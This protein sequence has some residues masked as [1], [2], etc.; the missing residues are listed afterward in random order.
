MLLINRLFIMVLFIFIVLIGFM[1]KDLN[2]LLVSIVI[3]FIHNIL[4]TFEKFYNRIVFFCFNVSIFIFLVARMI[5]SKLFEYGNQSIG[6]YGT[7]FQSEDVIFKILILLNLTLFFIFLGFRIQEKNVDNIFENKSQKTSDVMIN[8]LRKVSSVI[9]LISFALRI[10]YLME[11][12]KV[13]QTNG[14]FSYFSNFQS[15]LPTPIVII[16]EMMPVAFFC[17]L[18]TFPNKKRAFSIIALYLFE[19]V[20]SMFTGSRADFMLNILIVFIYFAFR[21]VRAKNSDEV[22]WLGK[23]EWLIA[24]INLPIL[25]VI[26]NTIETIRN[27]F[28]STTSSVSGAILSFFYAQGV[29]V[30]VIGYT[31]TLK[32]SIPDKLYTFGPIIEFFKFNIFGKLSGKYTEL[33]GQTIER[34][35]EGYQ[36]SHTISYLAM[37]Q[38]YLK[39]VG[40]GSSYVAELFHDYSYIGVILGS[41]F[42]GILIGQFTKLATSSKV[43]YVLIALLMIRKLLFIP[44][45]STIAFVIDTFSPVNIFTI[46]F[47]FG[48]AIILKKFSRKTEMQV[49]NL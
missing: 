42:I 5:V 37:P 23:K 31:E 45:A 22:A 48:L 15:S 19:G 1:L 35:M 41:I 4:Y 21:N 18:A 17:Y 39:G 11:A 40:Y 7:N 14:Y 28:A 36:Y 32:S 12:I 47:I 29:S 20:I 8:T 25:V 30:N 13:S 26:L 46:L 49:N 24:V 10:I 6:F 43:L 34:A 38:L 2:M 3:I 16:S 44:R 9:F 33:H 27:E